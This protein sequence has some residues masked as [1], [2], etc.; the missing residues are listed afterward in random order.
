MSS[1]HAVADTNNGTYTAV[2]DHCF[3]YSTLF[4]RLTMRLQIKRVFS[5]A[6]CNIPVYLASI[7]D[8]INYVLFPTVLYISL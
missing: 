5:T 4:R 6:A 7:G 2:E 3:E 8:F 1:D